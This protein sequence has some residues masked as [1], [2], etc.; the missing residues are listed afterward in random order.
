MN[1]GKHNVEVVSTS[2]NESKS[3]SRRVDCLF[4][5]DAGE[6]MRAYLYIT[7]KAEPYSLKKLAAMGWVGDDYMELHCE[8]SPLAGNRVQITVKEREYNGNTYNEIQWIDPIGGRFA[9]QEGEEAPF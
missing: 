9:E 2:I 6:T 4:Q 5:D 7:P 1:V 3:G 8:P